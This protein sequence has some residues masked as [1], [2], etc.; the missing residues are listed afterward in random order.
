MTHIGVRRGIVL[1]LVVSLCWGLVVPGIA[2]QDGTNNTS[3]NNSSIYETNESDFNSKSTN[4]TYSPAHTNA[5]TFNDSSTLGTVY[6]TLDTEHGPF[7]VQVTKLN[8]SI[9]AVVHDHESD[10]GVW[11]FPNKSS[12]SEHELW[13]NGNTRGWPGQ[14]NAETNTTRLAEEIKDTE[15]YD[16]EIVPFVTQVHKPKVDEYDKF[17][18][19]IGEVWFPVGSVIYQTFNAIVSSVGNQLQSMLNDFNE[20]M[21]G[22]PAPGE[23]TQPATWFQGEGWWPAVYG[24]FGIMAAL[25]IALLIPEMM[26]ALDTLDRRERG[27]R[28]LET[29]R[30]LVI[31]VILGIP[32][33]A[34][35][36]HLSNGITVAI[37][38]AG[39][40]YLA[41]PSSLA[42]V[43]LGMF[44]GFL[45]LFFKWVVLLLGILV[46][47]VQHFMMYL[48]VA[49][50]PLFW[51]LRRQPN[52][53]LRVFGKAGI[54]A[55]FILIMLKLFQVSILRFMAELPIT[56]GSMA[57]AVGAFF[58]LIVVTA[59]IF[60]A[61]IAIPY[62]LLLKVIPGSGNIVG[63]SYF[64]HTYDVRQ[65]GGMAHAMLPEP[66]ED[67]SDDD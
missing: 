53:S 17:G 47:M 4:D 48:V 66:R 18:V 54:N 23:P 46:V 36:L 57:G 44:L 43:G 3:E 38:P 31:G 67:S 11:Y 9:F 58:K 32:L 63:G 8:R 41:S 50:W 19:K 59:G 34:L 64:N 27:E 52:A 62:Y 45:L 65:S 22:L 35:M 29:M 20:A 24:L 28:L 49:F 51:A 30:S 26:M 10:T 2:A 55:F 12:N 5:P 7:Q 40:E 33:T 39:H 56:A 60:I 21:F 14:L 25:A 37:A 15:I 16:D 61:L 6:V 1:C 42:Q 13:I